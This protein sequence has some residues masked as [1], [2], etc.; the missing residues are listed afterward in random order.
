[1]EIIWT[2]KGLE[3]LDGIQ[4]YIAQ[5]SPL[6]ADIFVSELLD[7]VE[8]LAG[9]PSLGRVIPEMNEEDKREVIHENYRVLYYRAERI[10]VFRVIHGKQDFQP[11][12]LH[13][14]I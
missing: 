8:L 14:D 11:I 6:Q 10:Y 13:I 12:D 1:M 3:S 5:N 4:K 9:N 7:H 2:P